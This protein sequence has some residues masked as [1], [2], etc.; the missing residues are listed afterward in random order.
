M[1]SQAISVV[2]VKLFFGMA[3]GME[4]C[5]KEE[6]LHITN[7]ARGGGVFL[8]PYKSRPEPLASLARFDGDALT[9]KFM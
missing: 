1:A 3:K 6:P 5:M 7:V 8:P 2:T 9:R 4:F